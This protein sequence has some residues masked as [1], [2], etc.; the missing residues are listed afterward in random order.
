MLSVEYEMESIL[1]HLQDNTKEFRNAVIRFTNFSNDQLF[2]RPF[3]Q[4]FYVQSEKK[5]AIFISK[6]IGKSGTAATDYNN[7]LL[8][9]WRK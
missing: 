2:I 9:R 5:I 4:L 1:L 3:F 7:L 6:I 8:F